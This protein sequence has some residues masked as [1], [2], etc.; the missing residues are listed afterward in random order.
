MI[1]NILSIVFYLMSLLTFAAA[2][3]EAV[4]WE[5]GAKPDHRGAKVALGASVFFFLSGIVLQVSS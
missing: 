1:L 2:V 3:R 4:R 5:M